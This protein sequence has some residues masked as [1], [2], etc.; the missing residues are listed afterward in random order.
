ML[1]FV[2]LH[3]KS[4]IAS[5]IIN[6]AEKLKASLMHCSNLLH[7]QVKV[8]AQYHDLVALHSHHD[9]EY[10]EATHHHEYTEEYEC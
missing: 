1:F 8:D 3:Q 6:L 5:F 10:H 2:R 4:F 9:W 7:R